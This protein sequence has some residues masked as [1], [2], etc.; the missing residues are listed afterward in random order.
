MRA[1]RFGVFFAPF[2][3]PGQDPTLAMEYD[4][5]R[6]VLLDKLGYDEVW[7]GEHHSAGYEILACPEIMIGIAA[8]RTKRIMLGTGVTSLPYHHPFM[9]ADR[10]V[11]LDHLTRGRVILGC[12]PGAL[13]TDAYMMGIEP[14][15]Q[16][17]RMEESLEAI[18]AL[19]RGEVV[20]RKTDWFEL[21]EARLQILPYTRPRFEIAA[22]A[23]VTPSGPRAAGK[24]GVSL[25]SLGGIVVDPSVIE[26]PAALGGAWSI[27]EE[28]ASQAGNVVQRDS[29][30]VLSPV[31]VADTVS[32]ALRDVDHGLED[33]ANYFGGGGGFVLNPGEADSKSMA[34]SY[35]ESG[36]AV[37]GTPDDLI[38]HIERLQ[39]E[40]GGFG[41]FLVLGHD[42]AD[43][44]AT[45]RSYELISKYVIPHFK[46]RLQAPN[47]SHE[48]AKKMR[49]EIFA[50]SFGALGAE[51]A[52]F[53]GEHG[54]G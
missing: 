11:M 7:F 43:R 20:T 27:V 44:A 6:A 5:D 1:L 12:G 35:R 47:D 49:D 52:A 30:R 21:R 39:E 54:A 25:L 4:L 50:K 2:H 8:E 19:L 31:H 46:D 45:Y 48:W 41:T 28:N 40:S 24:F 22:A 51:V 18:L 17:R 29:W 32:Q 53:K 15:D 16:R 10:M 14:K 36:S 34:E 26:S 33:F 3:P 9:V 37:I 13:P 23:M 38:A 42:W